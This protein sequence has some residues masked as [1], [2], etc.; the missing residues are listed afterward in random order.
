[1]IV[2]V[3][4]LPTNF[5][6]L[7]EADQIAFSDA[8]KRAGLLGRVAVRVGPDADVSA[9]ERMLIAASG[10]CEIKIFPDAGSLDD[11]IVGGIERLFKIVVGD[12]LVGQ[13]TGPTGDS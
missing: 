7:T 10:F 8:V 5:S 12:D 2:P 1:M 13:R 9:L 3:L 6:E 11:P 4:T